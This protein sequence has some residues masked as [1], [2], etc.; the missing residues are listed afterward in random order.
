MITTATTERTT[1]IF[2]IRRRA[3]EVDVLTSTAAETIGTTE[4]R[5]FQ[6]PAS[7]E[8]AGLDSIP[9]PPMKT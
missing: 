8:R 5:F 7:Q 2:K 1:A 6:L 9:A 4:F 3:T